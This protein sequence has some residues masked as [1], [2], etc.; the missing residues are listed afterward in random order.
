[1][2]AR[3]DA[4]VVYRKN[5]DYKYV[6]RLRKKTGFFSIGYQLEVTGFEQNNPEGEDNRH[7]FYQEYWSSPSKRAIGKYIDRRHQDIRALRDEQ[8]WDAIYEAKQAKK[9]EEFEKKMERFLEKARR[10]WE[11]KQKKEKGEIE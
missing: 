8:D 5:P 11:A 9:K 6:Y 4:Q 7:Y 10:E 2:S 1:M 3:Y